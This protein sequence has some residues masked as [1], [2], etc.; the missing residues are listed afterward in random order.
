MGSEC[1]NSCHDASSTTPA[2]CP[3]VYAVG[4]ASSGWVDGENV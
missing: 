2:C 3:K 4:A 1:C